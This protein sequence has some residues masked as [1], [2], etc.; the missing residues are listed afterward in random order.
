MNRNQKMQH[1]LHVTFL[2]VLPQML[3]NTQV[4]EMEMKPAIPKALEPCAPMTHDVKIFRCFVPIVDE[5]SGKEK[6]VPVWHR[7]LFI[8]ASNGEFKIVAF[9]R[10]GEDFY[11]LHV[12]GKRRRKFSEGEFRAWLKKVKLPE[13]L[14]S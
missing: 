12:D 9:R 10:N 14:L 1:R 3:R 8:Y 2:R 7:Q 11:S 4:G 5:E 13:T 6:R